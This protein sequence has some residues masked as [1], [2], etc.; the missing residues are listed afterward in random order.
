[1][2]VR[3]ELRFLADVEAGVKIY[4]FDFEPA[5]VKDEDEECGLL[6]CNAISF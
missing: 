3:S 1:M 6:G 2:T 4:M 5:V